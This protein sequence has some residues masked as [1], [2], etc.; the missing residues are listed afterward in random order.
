MTRSSSLWGPGKTDK[1][2]TAWLIVTIYVVAFL[3]HFVWEMW[4]IPFYAEMTDANHWQ[5]LKLCTQATLGDGVIALLA[6]FLAVLI[7]RGYLF[8]QRRNPLIAWSVYL[9]SGLLITVALEHIATNVLNRWQYSELTPIVPYLNVGLMPMLQWLVLPPL[10]VW[11]SWVFVR[12]L[13]F[14][15]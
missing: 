15:L 11:I 6:F 14:G 7:S 8:W 3:L 10:T 2:T 13:R 12:G 5:A 9:S 1:A 4:Q